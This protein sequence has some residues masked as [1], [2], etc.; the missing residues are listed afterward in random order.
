MGVAEGLLGR[1]FMGTTLKL[2]RELHSAN[3]KVK[4]I[5]NKLSIHR[6]KR[7]AGSKSKKR[8]ARA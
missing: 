1:F 4:K 7:A 8:K 3:D 5:A 6:K 2:I